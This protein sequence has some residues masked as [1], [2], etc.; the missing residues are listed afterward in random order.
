MKKKNLKIHFSAG[1]RISL[2]IIA[3]LV[4]SLVVGV[5]AWVSLSNIKVNRFFYSET[6]NLD[7][8]VCL[9]ENQYFNQCLDKND[10]TSSY[11]ANLIDYI[12][13]EFKYVLNTSD[14]FDYTYKYYI[15]AQIIATEKGDNSKV[16]YNV[17]EILLPEKEVTMNN[18]NNLLITEVVNIGYERYNDIIKS[19]KQDYTLSLDSKLIITLHVSFT[20]KHSNFTDDISSN[21][22]ITMTIPLSE[23]T[24]NIQLDYVDI[25]DSKSI[26]SSFRD[27]SEN[28]ILYIVGGIFLIID[29]ILIICLFRLLNKIT[30][31]KT[32]YE[33]TLSK[34]MR[35]YNQIIIDTKKMPIINS[36][37]LIEVKSFEELLDAREMIGKPILYIKINNQKS[38]FMISNGNEVYKYTLKAIDLENEK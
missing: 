33:K 10:E 2:W 37:T 1:M 36:S 4:A 15:S 21:Q 28:M 6:S 16:I 23:Q 18:S 32:L 11:V 14:L 5:C 20:G 27:N 3:I 26:E 7:Y 22:N 38:C 35:E 30:V 34:I 24:I 8:K 19:L 13:A 29:F 12:E 31:T 9:K 17:E 25:N